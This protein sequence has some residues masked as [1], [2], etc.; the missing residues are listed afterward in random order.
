MRW[1]FLN[2]RQWSFRRPKL[3]LIFVLGLI[4]VFILAIFS[5]PTSTINS[6]FNNKADNELEINK[7]LN[8]TFAGLGNLT[9]S[10]TS[11]SLIP[12][13]A[14]VADKSLNASLS[15]STFSFNN[16]LNLNLELLECKDIH[17]YELTTQNNS[18]LCGFINGHCADSQSGVI[19]YLSVYYCENYSNKS[20]SLLFMGIVLITLFTTIGLAAADFL[21]PNLSSLANIC[22]LS[23]NVAGLTLLAFGNGSPDIFS[24]YIAM[25]NNSGSLAI[26]E[27]LG[28]ASFVT[29][30]VVGMMSIVNPFKVSEQEFIRDV[31]FFLFVVTIVLFI[32]GDGELSPLDSTVMLVTYITY[33]STVTWMNRKEN[34]E[35]DDNDDESVDHLS[36][37]SRIHIDISP[38]QSSDNLSLRPYNLSNMPSFSTSNINDNLI[39]PGPGASLSPAS[40]VYSKRSTGNR[41]RSQLKSEMEAFREFSSQLKLHRASIS[42]PRRERRSS[43]YPIDLKLSVYDAVKLLSIYNK[44]KSE[45]KKRQAQERSMHGNSLLSPSTPALLRLTDFRARANS[46]IH[47]S[48]MERVIDHNS[49]RSANNF[50]RAAS[51]DGSIAMDTEAIMNNFQNNSQENTRNITK[52]SEVEPAAHT[53]DTFLSVPTFSS[54]SATSRTSDD[55]STDSPLKLP[56]INTNLDSEPVSPAASIELIMEDAETSPMDNNIF[57]RRDTLADVQTQLENDFSKRFANIFSTIFPTLID[58][59]LQPWYSKL[60]SLFQAPI[61]FILTITIPVY[62]P[63]EE[64]N[65]DSKKDKAV[66]LA[67]S[68]WL[69]LVHCFMCPIFISTI[70]WDNT[71]FIPIISLAAVIGMT[72][73]AICFYLMI[74]KNKSNDP[75]LSNLLGFLCSLCWVYQIANEVVGLLKSAGI[76]LNLSEAVLGITVFAFGNSLGDLI[77]DITFAKLGFPIMALGACFGGPMLNILVGIG[78]SGLLTLLQQP[79]AIGNF[80]GSIKI[81]VERSLRISAG[82]LV[83]TMIFYLIYVP[84]NK[85]MLDKRAGSILVGIW[86][87][88]TTFNL[89]LEF[90]LD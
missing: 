51:L 42:G 84:W 31:S 8:I 40:S 58:F 48:E 69:Q 19:D 25:K 18:L 33:V 63:S 59:K 28:A 82:T 6:S 26:G 56:K 74:Y 7:D 66:D 86:V 30:M 81:E 79:N 83:F 55:T 87:V 27:L 34:A 44:T 24:T 36:I 68:G 37:D 20:V 53:M 46:V 85:W 57:G 52:I 15:N 41:H 5:K 10:N 88:S 32:V 76:I 54:S 22:G 9:S 72:L 89:L 77:S 29:T 62:D 73:F 2:V 23:E 39:S 70:F 50:K 71:Y 90:L 4:V 17:K 1:L 13:G 16:S 11:T 35:P 38:R 14:S 21:C 45:R 67:K 78:L 12:T 80:N 65:A 47:L 49:S 43:L 75:L 61:I 64:E 3:T 60:I